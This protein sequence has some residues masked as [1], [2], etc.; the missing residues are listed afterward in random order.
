MFSEKNGKNEAKANGWGTWILTLFQ[1]L[2]EIA[3]KFPL[4]PVA[5]DHGCH[6]CA[7][8]LGPSQLEEL[9]A[10]ISAFGAEATVR[11]SPRAWPFC[12]LA[13]ALGEGRQC[14]RWLRPLRV[15]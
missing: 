8:A 1:W 11:R 3:L 4:F 2:N 13:G 10:I 5:S 7:L 6:L 14:P 9:A 12:A 15:C